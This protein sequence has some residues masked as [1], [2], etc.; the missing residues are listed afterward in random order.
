LARRRLNTITIR[1]CDITGSINC[2][3]AGEHRIV[4]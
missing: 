3:G 4:K 1:D 2:W